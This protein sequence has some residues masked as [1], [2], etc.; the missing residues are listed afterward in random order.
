MSNVFV[1]LKTRAIYL[2]PEQ[3]KKENIKEFMNKKAKYYIPNYFSH[4][5]KCT[6]KI[7]RL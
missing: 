6:G 3:M 4:V 1:L 7:S 2:F 5:L